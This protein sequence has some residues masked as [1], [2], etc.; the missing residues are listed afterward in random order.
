[1]RQQMRRNQRM[2]NPCRAARLR[3]GLFAL[4]LTSGLAASS[5]PVLAQESDLN[6]LRGEI[7]SDG[8][9]TVG[10]LTQAVVEE[11]NALAPEVQISVAVSGTGGGFKRF[12]AGEIDISNASRS[13][14]DEERTICAEHGVD[15]YQFEVALDGITVV[16]NKENTWLSCISTYQLKQLWQKETSINTWTELNT[17]FPGAAISL[18]GPG[19]DSGTLDVFIEA[20][21]DGDEIR[22]DVMASE[23]DYVLVEGV[24]G[25][26]Y[27]LGYFG[28]AF[29]QA[30]QDV[31]NAVA[32]EP[33]DGNCVIPSPETVQD[34]TYKPLSRPLFI[35][36]RADA[37]GRPEVQ[38]FTR[39]YLDEAPA[40]A[41]EIGYVASPAEIYTADRQQFEA[42][43]SG[44]ATPNPA[45]AIA[46]PVS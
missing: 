15:W 8:S 6:A 46:T 20:I 11:F 39:F 26:F 23:D 9:S 5:L 38:E 19:P 13:I 12:C 44:A 22:Q 27:A 17:E 4:V 35:Y 43:L 1:M 34:G 28:L 7:A 24:A 25:D 36:V 29:Y 33:G 30:N 16:T 18:Y 31:L 21:L 3:Q 42:A 37:L 14:T 45:P 10:L 2:G 40:L 32:I 41:A